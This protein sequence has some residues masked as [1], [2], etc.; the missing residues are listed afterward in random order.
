MKLYLLTSLR[1][2][3]NH[4]KYLLINLLCLTIGVGSAFYIHLFVFKELSTDK[5][6]TN[7]EEIYKVVRPS[8]GSDIKFTNTYL[9]LGQLLKDEIPEI[10]NFVRIAELDY[11]QIV[12][13][14][15][16]YNLPV[17]LT[18]PTLFDLFDFE[19]AV[20]DKAI[21]VD[22]PNAIFLR[23]DI[24]I[25]FFG[26][27]NPLGKSFFIEVPGNP[28]DR[29]EFI[30]K[31]ILN[32]YPEQ[33]TIN[34]QMVGNIKLLEEKYGDNNWR[35]MIPDLYLNIKKNVN[36]SDV[37]S[38]INDIERDGI[39]SQFSGY[40]HLGPEYETLRLDDVYFNSSNIRGVARYG[41]K[42]LINI[43]SGI[44]AIILLLVGMNYVIL[45]LGI[46]TS[47]TREIQ[48]RRTLGASRVSI[49][50]QYLF[51]SILSTSIAFGIVLLLYPFVIDFLHNFQNYHYSIL[52]ETDLQLL[53]IFGLILI[54]QA[55]LIGLVLAF[56][57]QRIVSFVNINTNQIYWKN[58]I[59]QGLIQFQL[60]TTIVLLSSMLLINKQ[61]DSMKNADLGF[62]QKDAYSIIGGNDVL[63]EELSKRSFVKNLSIGNGIFQSEFRSQEVE[64]ENETIVNAQILQGNYQFID[65]YNIPLI[66]GKNLDS[67]NCF[68]TFGEFEKWSNSRN[69]GITQL[70]VNEKFVKEANLSDP[71]GAFVKGNYF[72]NGQIVGIIKDVRN[73]PLHYSNTPIVIG[74]RFRGFSM[75]VNFDIIEGSDAQIGTFLRDFY[76]DTGIDLNQRLWSFD[77]EKLYL[78][79]LT[80]QK[81][82][83]AFTLIILLTSCLGLFGLNLFISV[84][85]TKEIGIRKVNGAKIWEV[86]RLLNKAMIKWVIIAFF[87]ATPIAWYAMDQ[88]LQNFAYQTEL[89]WW[90]FAEAG[91]LALGIAILTVS[92]QSW[93]A[94]TRNPVEALRY[95]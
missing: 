62:K 1:R 75:Q 89:S 87:I 32:D 26:D 15:Q 56:V 91:L 39:K 28:N 71:L 59:Y 64:L 7:Y 14:E 65:L 23:R 36:L 3:L 70:L 52:P 78:K 25:K 42:K 92:W 76:K 49:L 29:L 74:S 43:L 17:T 41:D 95:E 19:L 44:G 20:G 63:L 37:I 66:A 5:F 31:G 18:D 48:T 60:I 79:E 94:A 61:V 40:T 73:L 68:N 53:S 84:S 51:D 13:N 50:F 6:H 85:R 10:E 82:I 24:A 57:T 54:I 77:F 55:V 83:V 33:S 30:V 22:N 90:I 27:S 35:S 46:T 58:Y 12:V 4:P 86:L 21:L 88:W 69:F 81:L 67:A 9:P 16:R 80:I 8:N 93:R 34:P 11:Y 38:K 2:A 47:K 45:N 72:P